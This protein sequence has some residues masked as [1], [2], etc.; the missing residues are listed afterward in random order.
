MSS[1]ASH[2]PDFCNALLDCYAA[3]VELVELHGPACLG[4]TMGLEFAVSL[5]KLGFSF[6]I[7]R[8]LQPRQIQPRWAAGRILA[9]GLPRSRVSL[10][11]DILRAC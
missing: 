1:S 7:P 6:D 11:L 8:S 3:N 4:N 10:M 5:P 9:N 2:T